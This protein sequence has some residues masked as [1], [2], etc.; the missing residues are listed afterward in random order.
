[1]VLYLSW[2]AFKFDRKFIV[3]RRGVVVLLILLGIQVFLGILTLINCV[4]H[5]PVTLG[6]LHQAGAVLFLSSILFVT[7]HLR[8][9]KLPTFVDK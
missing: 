2:S 6:V 7:F 5:I 9:K 3:L 8:V 4:G 1:M